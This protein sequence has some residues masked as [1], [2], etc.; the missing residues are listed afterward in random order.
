[1]AIDITYSYLRENLDAILNQVVDQQEA[2]I[3]R[4]KGGKAVALIPAAELAGLIETAH[5]LR[6]PK[7]AKRLMAAVNRSGKHAPKP[8]TVEQLRRDI[9]GDEGE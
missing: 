6:S 8:S 7:N 1:M 5:L 9:L 3:V 4:R 2:V